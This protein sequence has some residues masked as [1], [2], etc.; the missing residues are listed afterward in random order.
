[1]THPDENLRIVQAANSKF[2]E[3]IMSLDARNKRMEADLAEC[4]EFLERQCDVVEDNYAS[5]PIAPNK[6]MQLC[7]MIKCT[8]YG[9]GNW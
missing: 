9:E 2:A 4:L 5:P 6:A 7:S 3:T 1:M 8:L